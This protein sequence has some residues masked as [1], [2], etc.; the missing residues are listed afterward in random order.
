MESLT[1][2]FG[3]PFNWCDRRCERCMLASECPLR[4]RDLQQRWV[5]EAKGLDPDDPAVIMSDALAELPRI[6]KM[7]NQIAEEEGIDVNAPLPP[8]PV[9]L[10]A[11]RLRSAGMDVMKASGEH[12]DR[13]VRAIGT[14]LGMKAVRI[15]SHTEEEIPREVWVMDAEP[16]LLVMQRLKADLAT[17]LSEPGSERDAVEAELEALE[18]IISPLLGAVSDSAKAILAGLVERGAAPSPFCTLTS[19]EEPPRPENDISSPAR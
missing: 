13:E 18:R 14:C 5:A 11:R 8:R 15:S 3:A 4:K 12:G 1:N 17:R 7:V 16:N 9:R 19:Y 10:Q 6:E 2:I